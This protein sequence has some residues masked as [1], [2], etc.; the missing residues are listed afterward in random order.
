MFMF[1]MICFVDET[2]VKT[3]VKHRSI[4]VYM[5]LVIYNESLTLMF[6]M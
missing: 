4:T 1:T 3:I 6:Q 5:Y 2:I